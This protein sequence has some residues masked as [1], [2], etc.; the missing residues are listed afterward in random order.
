MKHPV[1]KFILRQR[2]SA[3]RKDEQ[4]VLQK[5]IDAYVTLF[6]VIGSSIAESR[7]GIALAEQQPDHL[8]ATEGIHLHLAQD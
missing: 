8:C 2:L 3:F 7:Y 6:T 4:Q 1:C 5:A